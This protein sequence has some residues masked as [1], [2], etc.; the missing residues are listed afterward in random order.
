[1]ICS[2]W[3]FCFGLILSEA[4]LGKACVLICIWLLQQK[5]PQPWGTDEHTAPH[6]TEKG[7]PRECN[8]DLRLRGKRAQA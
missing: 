8:V 4:M 3:M 7:V 6:T 5:G 2:G 1:M